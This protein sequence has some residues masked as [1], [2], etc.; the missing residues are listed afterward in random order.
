MK[1]IFYIFSIATLITSCVSKVPFSNVKE[2]EAT[3]IN[4]RTDNRY[5][6]PK[7]RYKPLFI[8]VNM[9]FLL[10]ENGEGNFNGKNK[11]DNEILETIFKRTNNL[12]ANLVDPKDPNCYKGDDFIKDTKIQFLFNPIYVKDTFARNYRNSKSFNL[13]KRGIGPIA[14]SNNWYLK[15]LDNNINDTI[16]K[17]GINA[18]FNMDVI[19]YNDVKYNNSSIEWDKTVSASVSQ[20]PSYTDFTRSSQICFPNKYTKRLLMENIYCVTHNLSW[21]NKV[22]NW[23]LETYR[24]IAH[25]IG[26]SLSLAHSNKHSPYNKCPNAM[27][28]QGY[29]SKNN[30]IQPS[31]IGKMHK[32]LMTTN[33][34]QYVEEDANYEVPKIVSENE[35]WDF[36]TIRF[37]QDIIIK[38][39]K[40]LI[41]NGNVILPSKASITLEKGAVLVLNKAMLKTATNQPFKNIIKNKNAKIIK[42]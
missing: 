13:K 33:L 38:K 35:N 32:A 2:I 40:I 4:Y 37:Y 28:Y 6:I 16:S 41:L 8:R 34:I 3:T 30:Y 12:Y 23:Y 14:P 5:F 1:K 11:E 19:A 17:K 10:D 7:E 20:F 22:K 31:E 24:G 42:Y 29:K 36:K 18:F 25:E 39:D 26:H 27:M 9:I 21:K 15:Y